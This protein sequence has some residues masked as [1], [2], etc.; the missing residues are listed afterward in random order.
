MV[1][2]RGQLAARY[3][4][5]QYGRVL[6]ASG[7]LAKANRIQF[8]GKENDAAS[9]ITY[10]GYRFY[11]ADLARWVNQDPAGFVDG[12]NL[13]AFVGN[14]PTLNFDP[15][16]LKLITHYEPNVERFGAMLLPL[17]KIQAIL[18]RAGH[19]DITDWSPTAYWDIPDH[20][21]DE[22]LAAFDEA[23]RLARLQNQN[24]QDR[25]LEGAM[26][27]GMS[28]LTALRNGS[29]TN[30]SWPTPKRESAKWP[31]TLRRR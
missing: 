2:A 18:E 24:D 16:G 10:F 27:V 14:S 30:R 20:I 22:V 29:S 26:R 13:Y 4:Y 28:V 12:P 8:S 21:I 6:A 17:N 3:L 7:P 25:R 11:D 5:E 23:D 19:V 1:D 9:G 31:R 15:F